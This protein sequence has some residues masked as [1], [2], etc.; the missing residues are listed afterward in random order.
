MLS[1]RMV[2]PSFGQNRALAS[3]SASQVGQRGTGQV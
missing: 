1:G 2:V 3:S